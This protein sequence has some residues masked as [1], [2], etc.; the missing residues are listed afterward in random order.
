MKNIMKNI[1]ID[2]DLTVVDVVK[3]WVLWY[4]NITGHDI[5]K[6]CVREVYNLQDL[7][8]EHD[9]PMSFWRQPNL[10]DNEIP[11][12][13]SVEVIKRLKT[14]FNIIFVSSCLPEHESS[15]RKFLDKFFGKVPFIST[16]SKEFVRA[17]FFI[18]DYR[19]YLDAV[20]ENKTECFQIQTKYNKVET[21]LNIYPNGNW[22][23]FEKFVEKSRRDKKWGKLKR[24]F[25]KS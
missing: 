13:G 1:M 12:N 18:D 22:Y 15:K 14:K 9:D 19:G 25:K 5:S 3:D 4:E 7:M 6:A 21:D 16:S 8:V 11:I 2:V 10:Y 23:D 20:N 17:D 24:E